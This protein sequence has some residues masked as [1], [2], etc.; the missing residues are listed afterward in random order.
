MR[1]SRFTEAQ[2]IGMIKEQE[3]GMTRPRRRSHSLCNHGVAPGG[4]LIWPEPMVWTPPP[5]GGDDCTV[6]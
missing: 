2:A 3:A 5:S 1:K 6:T 4:M